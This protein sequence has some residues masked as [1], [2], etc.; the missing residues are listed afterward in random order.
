MGDRIFVIVKGPSCFGVNLGLMM[1]RFRFLASSHTL[2]PCLNGVKERR[3]RVAMTCQA[4]SW[5]AKASLRA[6][7]RAFKRVSMAGIAVSE[8]IEGRA[9]GS[10]PIMR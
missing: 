1:R 4:S 2:S 10:Y 7:E 3:V 8:I 5:A 9:Q 6:V